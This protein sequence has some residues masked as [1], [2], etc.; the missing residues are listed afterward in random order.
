MKRTR[1]NDLNLLDIL[2]IILL[3]LIQTISITGLLNHSIFQYSFYLYTA[4][5]MFLL[6]QLIFIFPH[7]TK[8]LQLSD[9]RESFRKLWP[10]ILE[11]F[12][13]FTF[14]WYFK[15]QT[16]S[17][18]YLSYS[19][20]KFTNFHIHSLV[21]H[22]I[23]LI[24]LYGFCL[25]QEKLQMKETGA[26][27]PTRNRIIQRFILGLINISSPFVIFWVISNSNWESQAVYLSFLL[28]PF[29][30]NL[31]TL[32]I[33]QPFARFQPWNVAK[34]LVLYVLWHWIGMWVVGNLM[35]SFPNIYHVLGLI[36]FG[37]L[38][39]LL[40]TFQQNL[41]RSCSSPV[42]DILQSQPSR[43]S[44]SPTPLYCPSCANQISPQ[45]IQELSEDASIFC[46]QCGE[47]IRYQEIFQI[48]KEKILA[49]H[50]EFLRKVHQSTS[51]LKSHTNHQ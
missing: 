36:S 49:D 29:I 43:L 41:E 27:A 48:S 22:F 5:L 9:L 51:E 44:D 13:E 19:L 40:I 24:P 18:G 21:Y 7:G 3:S 26:S 30:L 25:L 1:L 28:I 35:S 46:V 50:Q 45:V 31:V 37:G 10:L 38:F 39:V 12:L 15:Q 6:F 14:F 23:L 2:K 34:H 16:N 47:K 8:H 32:K 11:I 4:L 20:E 33:L 17:A 42:T